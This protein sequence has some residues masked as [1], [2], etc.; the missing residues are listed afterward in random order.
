VRKLMRVL[1]LRML[2]P[3]QPSVYLYTKPNRR[4]L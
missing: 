1:A 3:P 4:R 2:K